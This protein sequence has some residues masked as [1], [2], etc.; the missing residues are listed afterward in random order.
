M[1]NKKIFKILGLV[2]LFLLIVF[3]WVVIRDAQ[4]KK[5]LNTP[6]PTGLENPFGVSGDDNELPEG[7]SD[8]ENN[9]TGN[10]TT[11]PPTIGTGGN[12][13]IVEDNPKLKQLSPDPVAGFTFWNEEREIP[14]S[15]STTLDASIV[16]VYDFSGYKTVRFGDKAD[17]IVTIKTV[18]NRQ[19]PSP[20]LIVDNNYDTDMKNAVVDFQNKNGLGG[21]GV[22]GPKTYAKFNAFQ[23]IT[24]FTAVKKPK[25]T[26]T[27][28]MTRYVDAG[29]GL[30]YDRAIR[31][32]EDKRQI[33]NNS[34]P[35]VAEA[36]F[37]N[38]KNNVVM[39][40]LKDDVIETYVAKLTFAKIDP[41]LTQAEKD[42]ITKI[43]EMTGEF[44]PEN[45]QT[46]AMSRDKKSLFYMNPLGSGVAGITYNF[47]TKAKKQIF[48]SPLREWIAGWSN[49]S[50]INLTTKASALAPGYA[51][52]LD[53]KTA[54]FSKVI[55]SSKGLTT[56]M[57]PDGKKILYAEVGDDG[58]ST[59]VIELATGKKTS[60]SP[61]AIPEKCIWTS[62]SKTIYCAAPVKSTPFV[63]PDDWYKGKVTFSDALWVIDATDYVGNI[64]YDFLSKNN[65]SIDA[66]NLE[67]RSEEDYIGF[68]NKKDG[69]LWGLDLAR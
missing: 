20:N 42:A 69:T 44:L 1:Q 43:A 50:K 48:D 22:I 47:S 7:Q 63:Y 12:M 19:T 26:E 36:F 34:I 49:D 62:D 31:K 18:L 58:I 5:I 33:T 27:V 41:N 38:T 29:S 53:T 17:E 6:T 61:S 54:A 16:E 3:S 32:V 45:I 35:R 46:V 15:D 9:G 64:E 56:L 10:S 30:L 68:I 28:A 55:G 51:Y 60:I 67:L 8:S 21:D 4:K 59:F 66:V 23:G 13:V 11:P 52:V 57:S 39:R 14:E 37:D 24:S 65:A 2:A 25:N 40:Y